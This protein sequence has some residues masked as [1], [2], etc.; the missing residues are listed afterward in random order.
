M[1]PRKP[2]DFF[3]E[4]SPLFA[5]KAA[6]KKKTVKKKVVVKKRARK[7][8]AIGDLFDAKKPT[9]KKR[10]PKSHAQLDEEKIVTENKRIAKKRVQREKNRPKKVEKSF[11]KVTSPTDC[12]NILPAFK[13][14]LKE[15]WELLE[16]GTLA[17]SSSVASYIN[18]VMSVCKEK[19]PKEY[20]ELYVLRLIAKRIYS[21]RSGN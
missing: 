15:Q 7:K 9:P 14:K 2:V 12:K 6:P 10:G 17:E 21:E 13:K 4:D 8:L 1:V 3:G 20:D 11:P 16:D 5:K 18:G 19:R